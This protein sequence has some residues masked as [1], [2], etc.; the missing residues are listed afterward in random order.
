MSELS[1]PIVEE[2]RFQ[3]KRNGKSDYYRFVYSGDEGL[4][5]LIHKWLVK[6]G[7]RNSILGYTKREIKHA[8]V[9]FRD[10]GMVLSLE[11]ELWLAARSKE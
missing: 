11:T 7:G 4:A 6:V 9:F 1:G 5:K 10:A 2:S 3:V 8:I